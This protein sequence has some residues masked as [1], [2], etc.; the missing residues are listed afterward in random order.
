MEQ[1]KVVREDWKLKEYRLH[2][3]PAVVTQ[4]KRLALERSE[5]EGKSVSWVAITREVLAQLAESTKWFGNSNLET[6]ENG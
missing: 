6:D 1:E 2:L 4:L 5:R 3:A